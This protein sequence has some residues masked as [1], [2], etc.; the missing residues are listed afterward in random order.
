MIKLLR[1]N[2]AHHI[3]LHLRQNFANQLFLALKI[4]SKLKNQKLDSRKEDI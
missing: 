1:I 4:E 2:I 3:C